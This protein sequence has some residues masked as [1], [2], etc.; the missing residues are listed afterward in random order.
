[1]L[2]KVRP[3]YETNTV[4]VHAF[5]RMLDHTDAMQASVQRL[6]AGKSDFQAAMAKMGLRCLSGQGN[7]LHV[8]FGEHAEKVHAALCDLV[9]YRKDFAEP[10]LRG[11]SRFSCTTP[12]L[13]QPVIDR[14]RLVVQG[15]QEV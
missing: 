9:I 5:E 2:H 12:D 7:F 3:M 1:M 13:F 14:I 6:L 4:A 11:F 15:A 10:C 8:A